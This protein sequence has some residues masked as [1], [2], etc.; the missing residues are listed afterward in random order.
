MSI[1]IIEFIFIWI[2]GRIQRPITT[3]SLPLKKSKKCL[4]I[5]L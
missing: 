1:I 3:R 2:E 5:I 4:D